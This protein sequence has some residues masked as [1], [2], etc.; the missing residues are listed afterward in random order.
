MAVSLKL[1]N[2]WRVI[3]D[4]DLK[5]IRASVDAR[6]DFWIVSDDVELARQLGALFSPGDRDAVHPW[7]ATLAARDVTVGAVEPSVAILVSRHADLSAD[8]ARVRSAMASHRVPTIAVIVGDRSGTADVPRRDESAR[9]A[10]PRLDEVTRP[11]VADAVLANMPIDLRMAVA[12]QLP[13]LRLGVMNAVIDDTARAN[14]SYALTTGLAEA[15]PVLTAPMNIGDMIILTKNQLLMSYRIALM[16]GRDGE[17]RAL[18]T[19]ILGVLGGGLLFRQ[20]ARQLVGL[21]PV[22]GLLPKI[23]IAY[24]GTWAIGKAMLLWATEGREVTVDVVRTYSQEGL[25]RGREVATTLMEKAREAPSA[26]RGRWDR[27]RQLVPGLGRRRE[28]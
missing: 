1:A 8:L 28:R 19:E 16:S 20:A 17:P 13:A 21:I 27:L 26:H 10:V 12:R 18:M 15:I 3:K 5:A 22:L 11:A 25:M 6:F 24:G 14:A 9:V 4:V 7:I 2:V 23:A